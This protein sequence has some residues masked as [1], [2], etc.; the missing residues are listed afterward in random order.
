MS[1]FQD[2]TGKQKGKKLVWKPRTYS[3]TLSLL[4]RFSL[5]RNDVIGT[6]INRLQRAPVLSVV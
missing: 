5:E 3:S 4:E 2:Q 6:L 1:E